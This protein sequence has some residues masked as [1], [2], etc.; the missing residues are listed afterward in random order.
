MFSVVH[1]TKEMFF[2][3]HGNNNSYENENEMATAT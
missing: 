3:M 1:K 2:Y